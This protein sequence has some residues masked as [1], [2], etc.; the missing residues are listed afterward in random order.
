MSVKSTGH[1]SHRCLIYSTNQCNLIPFNS[2]ITHI[3]YILLCL[4][5]SSTNLKQA[6]TTLDS[7]MCIYIHIHAVETQNLTQRRWHTSRLLWILSGNYQVFTSL[8]F[9]DVSVFVAFMYVVCCINLND[10]YLCLKL[11]SLFHK[12]V[13]K[14]ISCATSRHLRT[15]VLIWFESICELY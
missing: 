10:I 15:S 3:S 7:I 5:I 1:L 11:C 13:A 2:P 14:P 12:F 8:Y 9:I 6:K 4:A